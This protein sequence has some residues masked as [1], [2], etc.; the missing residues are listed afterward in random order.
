MVPGSLQ[1]TLTWGD[2]DPAGIIYYPTYYRWMDAA[3]WSLVAAAGYPAT[4]MRA[5]QCTMPLVHAAC[6]FLS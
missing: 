5:E 1:R 4:R 3:T 2:C 6:D